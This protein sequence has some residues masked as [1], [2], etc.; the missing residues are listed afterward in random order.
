MAIPI[1]LPENPKRSVPNDIK[2]VNRGT[3]RGPPRVEDCIFAEMDKGDAFIMLASAYHGGGTNSTKDEK[4][5]VFATFSV[6]G[7]LRQEENQFLAV[8]REIAKKLDQPIQAFMGYSLS[9][10]ACGYVEEIDPIYLLRPE[11]KVGPSDF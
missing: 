2:P 6:R 4:R 8:D 5:L 3:A 9:E 7:F 1:L 10:P 11:L